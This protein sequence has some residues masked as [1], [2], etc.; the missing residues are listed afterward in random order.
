M[1]LWY[2]WRTDTIRFTT[3]TPRPR[4]GDWPR[5]G[6]HCK[7]TDNHCRARAL[8]NGRCKYHGG[9]STGPKTSAGK[10]R[11]LANLKQFRKPRHS[12]KL[13]IEKARN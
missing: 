9:L 13:T 2:D 11:A 3:K 1:S 6:A 7:H 12:T 10:A 8:T 4:S 5:C